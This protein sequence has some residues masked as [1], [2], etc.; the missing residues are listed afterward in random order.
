MYGERKPEQCMGAMTPS[1]K[2]AFSP[3]AIQI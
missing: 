1:V 2:E 3:N